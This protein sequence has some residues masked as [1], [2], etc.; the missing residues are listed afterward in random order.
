MG[1]K[2]T[3]AGDE[4][5]RESPSKASQGQQARILSA[6]VSS[7]GQRGLETAEGGEDPGVGGDASKFIPGA[8]PTS[9]Q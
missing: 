7:M 8:K 9:Q 2:E 4:M 1:E 3:T 5:L 6:A